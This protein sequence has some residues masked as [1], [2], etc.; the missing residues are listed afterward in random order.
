M[1]RVQRNLHQNPKAKAAYAIARNSYFQA[2]KVAK[3]N[4][5]N[6]FLEN[7]DP[8]S[9]Y[10]AM[11]YT[12]DYE[13]RKLPP[14]LNK[15]DFKDK[16]I[17]L[18]QTLFPAPPLA[19]K[20]SWD[21][22]TPMEWNWA[23]LDYKELE[24]ACST[25]RVK[26]KT[27]GPDSINQEIIQHAF[28]ACPIIFYRLYSCL[29]NIGY[30]PKCWKQ[31]TGAILKKPSKPNYTIPKAYRVIALLNC[32]GKVSERIL[33]QRLGF[34][35]ETSTL[36]HPSQMGGRLKKSA[37]DT[38]LLLSNEIELNRLAKKKTT[39]LF[40]DVKGAFDHVAKNQLITILQKLRLPCSI[41]AWIASFL[42]N[43]ELRL[44]F[45]G[46]TEEFS[47]IN[48]GIPQGSPISPI[49]FLIYI[50]D[51]FP[52]LLRSN[53]KALSYMDDIALA[54]SSTS[55]SK[56]VKILEREVAKLQ[57][58]ATE[59]AIQFDLAKTELIHFGT[60]NSSKSLKLP[61]GVAI[62][63]KEVVRW[64]GI[65]FDSKLTFK[66]HLNTRVSQAKS[67]FLRMARLANT[68][69]GL[70][71]Y[72]MRQL[73]L[74][75]ITSVA[76]YGSIIWWKNQT[77]FYKPLQALQNLALRKILGVFKTSP[78]VPMELEAALYPPSIRLNTT[79][80]KYA[81]RQLKL[82]QNHPIRQMFTATNVGSQ[83]TRILDSI[84]GLVNFSTL[85][86]I[87]HF[88]YAPWE[89]TTPY[90]VAISSLSKEEEAIAHKNSTS[91]LQLKTLIAYSD[92][93]QRTDSYGYKTGIGVGI[94]FYNSS[95]QLLDQ[96]TTNIGSHQ[97]VYNGELE[98]VTRAIEIASQR[99]K[100]GETYKIYTDNQ[101]GLH[102]LATVSDNPGQ[103]CQ[104]RAINASKELVQKGATIT[105]NW[106][107]GHT[108]IAGNE[109]ADKLAKEATLQA[110]TTRE[111]S[112]A[113][114][115]LKAKELARREWTQADYSLF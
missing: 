98:G 28:R 64:L 11:A 18:R 46:Q 58:K 38:A 31:A 113:V 79:L 8:Q 95:L 70:T 109:L 107:P 20:P 40:L 100:P 84:K 53:L 67:A 34:L 75:C 104:I 43:R 89:R 12:K 110:T 21:R 91:N 86:P 62:E 97:I 59:A 77:Q 55:I 63:P 68:E 61:N 36:L 106:V 105:L 114:L 35:A 30:H 115:Q 27:P 32:L 94:A 6:K 81:I 51:L 10:K 16:A 93:S 103:A 71:P 24:L 3:K 7:E 45:D 2:I 44:S 66:Q 85:E 65:W 15:V 50:R 26:G 76:D 73:Y 48:I 19:T 88:A 33:A 29:L 49:L 4:H 56:N 22:Y 74:A 57:Q 9:I 112:F 111:T 52:D 102:R 17:I 78:I 99:A 47:E 92:A 41:I 72:A 39:V 83:A 108:D 14:I 25:S 60:K 80:R 54:T 42:S 1:L 87:Q 23:L 96:S 90:K 13:A 37:I 82:A 69:K 5:W 101:A